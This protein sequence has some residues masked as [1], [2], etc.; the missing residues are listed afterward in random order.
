MVLKDLAKIKKNNSMN[1]LGVYVC[2]GCD[3]F[4]SKLSILTKHFPQHVFGSVIVIL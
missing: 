1:K 3:I 2:K 4:L